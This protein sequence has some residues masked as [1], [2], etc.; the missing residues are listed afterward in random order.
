MRSMTTSGTA[1]EAE[2]DVERDV[3]EE[4]GGDHRFGRGPARRSE[5]DEPQRRNDSEDDQGD[6]HAVA[7]EVAARPMVRAVVAEEPVDAPHR[8]RIIAIGPPDAARQTEAP[9]VSL[10]AD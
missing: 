10:G 7:G 5:R 8:R 9:P 4:G 2:R 3:L 6:P 1:I